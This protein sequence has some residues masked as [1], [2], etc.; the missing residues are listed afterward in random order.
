M[1]IVTLKST[2]LADQYPSLF[3][4][5]SQQL[6]IAYPLGWKLL[7]EELFSRLDEL[8]DG[9]DEQLTYLQLAFRSGRLR[10]VWQLRPWLPFAPPITQSDMCYTQILPVRLES[11]SGRV[12]HA[13]NCAEFAS[14]STCQDCGVAK[15]IEHDFDFE[16]ALAL[17][18]TCR[19]KNGYPPEKSGLVSVE[20]R[21]RL[22]LSFSRMCESLQ[23]MGRQL[24]ISTDALVETDTRS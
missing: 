9:R 24:R 6:H 15:R 13:I 3:R 7:V 22:G 19:V 12:G 2:D 11:I 20:V 23:G 21:L 18:I 5:I 1:D 4:H 8:L 16:N 17:C 10:V 14:W